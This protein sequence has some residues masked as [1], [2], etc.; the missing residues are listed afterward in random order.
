LWKGNASRKDNLIL[1][2]KA[3]KGE[4]RFK[5]RDIG[6]DK[7]GGG[8]RGESQSMRGKKGVKRK[9]AEEVKKGVNV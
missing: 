8:R 2:F 9:G 5:P 4:N 3:Q 7:K 1:R 6:E